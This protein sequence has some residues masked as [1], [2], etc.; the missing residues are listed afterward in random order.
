[1]YQEAGYG[2]NWQPE[3]NNARR[4]NPNTQT[5]VVLGGLFAIGFVLIVIVVLSL[6]PLY[7]SHGSSS[8]NTNTNTTN[9]NIQVSQIFVSSY[10]LEIQSPFDSFNSQTILLETNNR[11]ALQAAL[12]SMIQKDSL[13]TGSV[14]DI[15]NT[16]MNSN[17]QIRQTSNFIKIIF[18]LN[19]IS[20]KPCSIVSC[21]NAFQ[22]RVIEL[23][24]GSN[25][26][27][28]RVYCE[29]TNSTEVYW[30]YFQLPQTIQPNSSLIYADLNKISSLLGQLLTIDK[31][32]NQQTIESSTSNLFA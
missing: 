24:S 32:R 29:R 2:A 28:S 10:S 12:T 20:S 21:L 30:L 14:I 16:S 15:N 5:C 25:M 7:M 6:I 23:L 1:M 11:Q 13:V 9:N 26:T 4:I 22:S 18:D 17:R 8:K 19:I 27:T 3:A 31:N